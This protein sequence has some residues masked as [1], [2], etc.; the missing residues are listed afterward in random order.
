MLSRGDLIA[1]V[2]ALPSGLPVQVVYG[3]ADAIT[4]PDANLRVAGARAGAPVTVLENAGHACYVEQ[5]E[6][7]SRA[8]EEFASKHG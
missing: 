6:S 8:V 2:E 4:L 3:G 7:F 5:P 1:D